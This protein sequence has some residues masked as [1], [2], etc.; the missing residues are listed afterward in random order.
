MSAEQ[1]K[2]TYCW[3]LCALQ[4]ETPQ[5]VEGSITKNCRTCDRPV[6]Y[7]PRSS[8]PA[9]GIEM[10]TCVHCLMEELP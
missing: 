6:W 9:L 7:D 3:R 10:I 1:M 2:M 4:E 5:L 8:I